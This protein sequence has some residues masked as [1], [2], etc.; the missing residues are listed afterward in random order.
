MTEDLS[1][2]EIQQ[3]VD[4]A[5]EELL[6]AAHVMGPP[7]DAL[8]LAPLVPGLVI[9]FED[10]APVRGRTR[11][12]GAGQPILLRPDET[13]ERKH[14]TVAQALGTF[15]KPDLLKRLGIGPE[16]ARTLGSASLVRLF[17]ERLLVPTSWFAADARALGYDL[18]EL[19]IRYRTASHEI[20]ADRLL[21]LPEPSIITVVDNGHVQRRRSNAWRVNRTLEPAERQCQAYVHSFSRPRVVR[22][23]GWTVQGWPVHQSDWKREM[24]RSVVEE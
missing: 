18:L 15:F 19:K 24:L 1:R 12:V 13:E 5:V 10:R 2:E 3:A 21:D 20:L 22:A 7:I 23:D 11:R 8:R 16:Q 9:T 4:R 6:A 14:W 17:A